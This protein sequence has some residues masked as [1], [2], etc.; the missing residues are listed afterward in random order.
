MR[1]SGPLPVS[2]RVSLYRS[3]V[4]LLLF[5]FAMGTRAQ[6]T[7]T[8]QTAV[9]SVSAAQT[10]TVTMIHDGVALPP[11]VTTQGKLLGDFAAGLGGSC[12]LIGL[13]RAGQQCTVSV[14]F[15]PK[16]PG[17]RTGAVVVLAADGTVLGETLLSG[18]GKG[19]LAVLQPGRIDTL[20]G[21]GQ[22][23]FRGD[24]V[25]GI[26]APVFLPGGVVMDAVGNIFLSDSSNNRI[27]RVDA[28][29]G[30]ITTVAGTGIPAYSGDGGPALLAAV[31][32]P[33]GIAMDGAG[34]LYFADSGNHVVRKIDAFSGVIMTV[35]GTG[36]QGFAGDG[37]AA[38]A[39]RLSLPEAVTLDG[40]GNLYI[41]D[42]GNNVVRRVD[43]ATGVIRT[44]AGTG[45]EGFSG[46]G[47][48]ATSAQLHT[49]W[50]IALAV[51]GALYIADLTNN[52]VR[53][54]SA[55][56]TI[57]TVAGTGIR[58]FDA[59]GAL[60][61]SS[62]LNNPAAVALDPA[63]NIYIA[64]SGNN[65]VRKVN[66]AS[67]KLETIAGN[68]S[69]EFTGDAGPATRAGLYGPYALYL[70]ASG[71]VLFSD[72][73]HNRIRRIS[74]TAI[75]FQYDTIRVSK[76]SP[77]QM[78]GLENNGND[79]LRF[80]T[81]GFLH[82]SLNPVTTT[83]T[84]TLAIAAWCQLGVEFAPTIVGNP[85]L[86]LLTV[87]SN[88]GNG[89]DLI[90]LTGNVLTVNPTSTVLTSSAN[91]SL[92]NAPV[93]LTATV[94]SSDSGRSGKVTFLEGS[95]P[96]CSATLNAQGVAT[97]TIGAPVTLALGQHLLTA[98]Y[99]G[100]AN[101]A[102]S[103]SAT[104][105]Q[106]VKQNPS[107]ALAVTPNP[108]VV[109]G[110][111]TMTAT[112]AAATGTPTGAVTF[113][114]GSQQVGSATLNAAGVATWST[115]QLK[116]GTHTLTAKY[117]GDA[118]NMNADSNA[119]TEAVQ[120][121]ATNVTLATSNVEIP[122]GAMVTL[123]ANV[124]SMNGPAP[125]GTVQ[126][127][128]GTALL[129]IGTLDS[130]GVAML[131]L[132]SLAPGV[133]KIV[134]QYDG[135]EN[136]A[137]G[138]SAVLLQTVDQLTTITLLAADANPVNAGASLNLTATVQ[139]GPGVL[140]AGAITGSVEFIENGKLLASVALAADGT[141]HFAVATLSVGPHTITAA[142]KG[143]TNYD[144][145][146]SSTLLETV[147]QTTTL[148][149]LSADTANVLAGKPVTLTA[150]VTSA[151]G[152]PAGTVN[153]MDGAVSLGQGTL[154]AKGVASGTLSTLAIGAH[155]VTAVYAGDA[156]Y[157][158]STSV[159][160][161]LSVSLATT[162]LSLSGPAK[163]EA[164][165]DGSFSVSLT[166]NGI[167]P[168]GSITLHDGTA[169]AGT[170]AMPTSGVATFRLAA[171]SP[172]LHVLRASYDGDAKNAPA[173]SAVL[174]VTVEQAATAT[175]LVSSKNPVTLAQPVTLTATVTTSSP[176]AGGSVSF[177]DNGVEIGAATLSAAGSAMFTTSSL[178]SGNHALTAVYS[179]DVNHSGSASS[180]L[181]ELV[182][183]A[184]QI[185]LGSNMNPAPA[186][187]AVVFSAK[188]S[189]PQAIVPTGSVTFLDGGT[190]L[191][192]AVLDANGAASLSSSALAVGSHTVTAAYEGDSHLAA[193]ISSPLVQTI[194]NAS[195]QVVLTASAE[196]ATYAAALTFTVAVTTNGGIATG[197]V[198]FSDGANALGTAVL[199]ATGKATL[200]LSNLAPGVHTVVANYAGD[201]KAS[202]S[203]SSPL[204][205]TV[206]Q[207]TS[208]ALASNANPA[209]TLAEVKIVANVT[210][211]GILAPTGIVTFLDGSTQLGTATVDATGRASLT[212]PQLSAGTH[213]IQANYGGDVADFTSGSAAFKQEVGLRAT[214]TA[215]TATATN[216][217]DPT[218][219]T[220]IAVVRW[221]GPIAP[222][223]T[224]TLTSG[225]V[226]I[227]SV[228]IDAMGVG[229]T[230]IFVQS[231]TKTVSASYGGD[232]SYAGSDS[233][234]TAIVAGPASQFTMSLAPA[235]L[236]M[237][238]KEHGITTLTLK[239]VKG[240]TDTMQF[241]CAGLP[242]AATCT[243][244][245]RTAKLSADSTLE[246]QL[247]VDTGNPLGA[248]A[249]ASNAHGNAAWAAFPPLAFAMGMLWIRR[250]KLP[251]IGALA[252]VIFATLAALSTTGCA[253]LSQAGTPAGTY[254]F[255]VTAYGQGSGAQQVQ[256]MTLVVTR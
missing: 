23:L 230:N 133:H 198:S 244:S 1:I 43:V 135:D 250:R 249:Q 254:Q 233:A 207:V 12:G 129:G 97:C 93:T 20:A 4:A 113:F 74:A 82:A 202:A 128:E 110:T 24:N 193:V 132:G 174:T 73:F 164:G 181:N 27:R 220:L 200:T 64:D 130:N 84:N 238:S 180:S 216:P 201:G 156:S 63:G 41:S 51:D 22:W 29:T 158:T 6:L 148:T 62:P 80:A 136:S 163:L 126:F 168:T 91:P 155:I 102:T 19:S 71:D 137:T 151:S 104:L 219:V 96:L 169:V 70:A 256:T 88:A 234:A 15:Q 143:N 33:A 92:L 226:T 175:V 69:E 204:T 184:S 52:R 53:K 117:A 191:G 185:A 37:A 237:V 134:A 140:T 243:F 213:T 177:R 47:G 203:V 125:T 242:F 196:P 231:G 118:T 138:K 248:G 76:V 42:S 98:S 224:V 239:S 8:G 208:V 218:Q 189:G 232:A 171:M 251:S 30:I 247:T 166:T 210:T 245:Q 116:A 153:F 170:Q 253:G 192:S 66:V 172:G 187:A 195:T 215:L 228:Q 188:V 211:T 236:T 72:I 59:D 89:P 56:G 77:P 149:T 57:S 182:V 214:T 223:G 111:V 165:T 141:A 79:V 112:V 5:V 25:P 152:I 209:Q 35:A 115:T 122:V 154:D 45:S 67:G 131:A 197:K 103:L 58:A 246:V 44:V 114:D 183:Q 235:K 221:N 13:V 227:G 161:N 87:N 146:N 212:V 99:A 28:L 150:V 106:V 199:D 11:V 160:V 252:L 147:R 121:A 217:A 81:H 16:F 36:A 144:V 173:L 32:N 10:V 31:S 145:S 2:H 26:N 55:G 65:R 225:G 100:D 85:V 162:S 90:S 124:A 101:N 94:T 78:E 119:V 61:T 3:V 21:D 167:A 39:A 17:L 108:A 120:T 14:L 176:N 205:V 86:G 255:Q 18:V 190:T 38:I 105:T 241:G 54:V 83:C 75:G 127:M 178:A 107:V 240:F 123:T 40:A 68:G 194:Q 179:G 48:A 60:A 139:P 142:Y 229:T 222:T 159:V 109:T 50:G 9:G 157:T 7:F 206:K 186:G 34:N 95:S 46:D 49:P